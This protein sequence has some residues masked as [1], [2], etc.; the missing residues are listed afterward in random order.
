MAII[1]N[2]DAR[3]FVAV[4]IDAFKRPASRRFWVHAGSGPPKTAAPRTVRLWHAIPDAQILGRVEDGGAFESLRAHE[5]H[6]SHRQFTAGIRVD[7]QEKRVEAISHL[8]RIELPFPRHSIVQ[9][10]PFDARTA[11]QVGVR[12]VTK[13][14]HPPPICEGS[15]RVVRSQAFVAVPRKNFLVVIGVKLHVQTDLSQVVQAGDPLP[16]LFRLPERREKHAGEY[17]D[18]S[19]DYEKFDQRKPR[20]EFFGDSHD[21]HKE[22]KI[23]LGKVP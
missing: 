5:P 7:S 18:N 16:F 1:E 2:D 17:R 3:L 9:P 4:V 14:G 21:T 23:S 6:S 12:D 8:V 19:N 15:V 20:A 10:L 13:N 22:P 11:E